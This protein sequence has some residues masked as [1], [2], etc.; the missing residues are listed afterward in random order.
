M[1]KPINEIK[2]T[3]QTTAY[4]RKNIFKLIW[5]VYVWKISQLHCILIYFAY[6]FPDSN[7]LVYVYWFF[8]I[9]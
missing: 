1:T 8:V 2:M 3:E 4:L 5:Y 9:Q 6:T 7:I